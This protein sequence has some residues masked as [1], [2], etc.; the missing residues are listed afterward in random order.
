MRRSAMG[1]VLAA[2]LGIAAGLPE[3]A[4]AQAQGALVRSVE[5]L[6]KLLSRSSEQSAIEKLSKLGASRT[7]EDIEKAVGA[8]QAGPARPPGYPFQSGELRSRWR[9]DPTTA[10]ERMTGAARLSLE[11]E[12]KIVAAAQKAVLRHRLEE[13]IRAVAPGVYFPAELDSVHVVISEP[14]QFL[15]I[16]EEMRRAKSAGESRSVFAECS[17]EICF[18]SRAASISA[19]CGDVV[20]QVSTKAQLALS[21]DS[22]TRTLSVQ[23]GE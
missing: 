13:K 18:G 7:V 9:E 5:E 4:H 11:L 23:I 3:P 14:Q 19:A 21:V 6:V 15:A 1:I 12:L 8:G 22:G 2:A 17:F 20:L 16:V 10:V